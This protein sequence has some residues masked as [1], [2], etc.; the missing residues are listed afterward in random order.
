MTTTPPWL[1]VTREQ[2]KQ[3][4]FERRGLIAFQRSYIWIADLDHDR[5]CVRNPELELL[6]EDMKLG[7]IRSDK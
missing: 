3:G 5:V 2:F 6:E 1:I 7:A 4:W